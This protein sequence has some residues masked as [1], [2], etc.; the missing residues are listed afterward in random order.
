MNCQDY[1]CIFFLEFR[2]NMYMVGKNEG[3][4]VGN[5]NVKSMYMKPKHVHVVNTLIYRRLNIE[6]YHHV[7]VCAKF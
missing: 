6:N 4:S 3:K 1:K 7:H 2:T 5:E